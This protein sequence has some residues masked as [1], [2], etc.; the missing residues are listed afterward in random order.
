[1]GNDVRDFLRLRKKFFRVR[2]ISKAV[3]KTLAS[4]NRILNNMV[5]WGDAKMVKRV[6]RCGRSP[7]KRKV[8]YF[9]F[10]RR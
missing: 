9:K 10:A 5:R 7:N 6:E 4:T 8:K 2:D 3:N 1:M